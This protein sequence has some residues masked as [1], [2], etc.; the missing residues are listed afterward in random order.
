MIRV[1]I[2]TV[3]FNTYKN[4]YTYAMI[5]SKDP[6]RE[7]EKLLK[8]LDA[9]FQ[10]PVSPRFNVGFDMTNNEVVDYH[11]DDENNEVLITMDIP[12]F[13]K[14]E[15]QL[16]VSDDEKYLIIDAQK[17]TGEHDETRRQIHSRSI[18]KQL[19]LDF[20]YDPEEITAEYTN[21]VLTVTI[22]RLDSADEDEN[23]YT[24]DIN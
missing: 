3:N 4:V 5:G 15:I 16:S 9:Q 20:E 19:P 21:G 22:P 14:D 10:R 1:I 24:I 17:E 23:A 12:G 2:Y 18:S 6:F 7:F 13:E 8:E 11:E